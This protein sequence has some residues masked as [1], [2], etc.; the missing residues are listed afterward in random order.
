MG[1]HIRGFIF[2]LQKDA[3]GWQPGL[4]GGNQQG[5]GGAGGTARQL[6]EERDAGGAQLERGKS[7][8]IPPRLD[9]AWTEEPALP[10]QAAHTLSAMP[11]SRTASTQSSPQRPARCLEPCCKHSASLAAEQLAAACSRALWA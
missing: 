7:C 1:A 2:T 11:P 9:R 4:P 10:I 6:T 3:R 8:V 5:R